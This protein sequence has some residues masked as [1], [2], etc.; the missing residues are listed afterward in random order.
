[1]KLA[2]LTL[3]TAIQEFNATNDPEKRKQIA[4]RWFERNAAITLDEIQNHLKRS[5]DR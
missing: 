5:S 1:M 3:K 2:A 4:V